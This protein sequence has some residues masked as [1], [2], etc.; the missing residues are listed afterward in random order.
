MNMPTS[1]IDPGDAAAAAALTGSLAVCE[2]GRPPFETDLDGVQGAA[3]PYGQGV[4][5]TA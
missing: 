4:G 5:L 3:D 1:D 2:T